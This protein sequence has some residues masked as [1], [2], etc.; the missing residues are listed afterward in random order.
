MI[1][2]LMNEKALTLDIAFFDS[3]T[4]KTDKPFS[5]M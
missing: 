3:I 2:W 5:T 1:I 4:F